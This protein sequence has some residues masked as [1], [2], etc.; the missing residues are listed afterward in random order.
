MLGTVGF[1]LKETFGIGHGGGWG[2]V[3][4]IA[5]PWRRRGNDFLAIPKV[6]QRDCGSD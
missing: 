4:L 3:T 5:G 2:P 1:D 6:D